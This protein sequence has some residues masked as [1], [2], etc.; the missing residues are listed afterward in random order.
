MIVGDYPHGTDVVDV[1]ATGLISLITDA[2]N[3]GQDQAGASIGEPTS[4]VV[5]CAVN[6]TAP[7]L[8]RECLVLAKKIAG[9]AV[10]ALSQPVFG[11]EPLRRLRD[12]YE[13]GHG[14]LRLPLLAGVLPLMS[15]RHAEF[16][17]NEVPGVSIPEEI[18]ERMR[19]AGD[20]AEKERLR[21]A[22]DLAAELRA[23]AAGICRH[24]RPQGRRR[25]EAPV[26]RH[27][28]QPQGARVDPARD[29]Q[30]EDR[31]S[32]VEDEQLEVMERRE[33]TWTHRPASAEAAVAQAR[34]ALTELQ[35]S[36]EHELDEIAKEL[37]A[38]EAPARVPRC[39][40]STTTCSTC[41]RTSGGQKRGVGAA[42]LV[43]G[44][45]QGCHQK[46]SAASWP[47]SRRRRETASGGA[48]T[49]ARLR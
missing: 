4:F 26:R 45:C 40:S 31:K 38:L 7:D 17:H 35:G 1:T 33:Q 19:S 39:R 14:E 24:D 2:F 42:A 22:V 16:L 23:D 41:T 27:R 46:L 36:A 28:G 47:G 8:E 34:T 5:G 44:V 6:P 13:A 11:S 15:A 9:G 29:H 32:R 12:V 43:D 48:S 10:F 25:G 37:A 21:I 3:Q 30:P 49:P 18:R 20:V